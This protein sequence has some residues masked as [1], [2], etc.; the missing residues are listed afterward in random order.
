[1]NIDLNTLKKRVLSDVIKCSY[2]G[3][4]EWSCPTL[5]VGDNFR[6]YGPRGRINIIIFALRENIWD[7]ILI[8]SIF[9]C[10]LCKVCNSQCPAGIDITGNIRD[11]RYYIKN[12]K[13]V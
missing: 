13:I 2:C 9:S 4:C 7:D 3:L 11:F 10:L 1:M 5:K 8:D 6:F 12:K